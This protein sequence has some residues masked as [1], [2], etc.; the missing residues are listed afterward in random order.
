MT[1]DK[2]SA[3]STLFDVLRNYL[4]IMA[5]FTPFITEEIWQKLNGFI[6]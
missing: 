4:K 5:P 6:E 3:Y 1:T 2:F